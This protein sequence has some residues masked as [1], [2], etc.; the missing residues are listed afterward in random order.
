MNSQQIINLINIQLQTFL[1]KIFRKSMKEACQ[2]NHKIFLKQSIK[3][4]DTKITFQKKSIFLKN[5]Y[6]IR[7]DNKNK[8]YM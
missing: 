5:H 4:A 6:K 7:N 3:K 8:R 2:L 1:R